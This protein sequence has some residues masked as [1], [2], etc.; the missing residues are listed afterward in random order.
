MSD[1]HRRSR[2]VIALHSPTGEGWTGHARRARSYQTAKCSRTNVGISFTR[3]ASD[4]TSIE[5]ILRLWLIGVGVGVSA[6]AYTATG[7]GPYYAVPSWDQTLPGATRFLVLT[8]MDS[9]AVLDRE[10][11]VVWE[12]S[13]A[14]GAQNWLLA[15]FHCNKKYV[16]IHLRWRLPTF[17]ELA[18][19]VDRTAPPGSPPNFNPPLP[20]GHPFANVLTTDYW[21][22]TS[23]DSNVAWTVS[24][25]SGVVFGNNLKTNAN[26]VWCV[27]G[28]QGVD[29][30]SMKRR[31]G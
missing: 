2:P 3:E 11:G 31:S 4:D 5:N 14:V 26:R 23:R 29:T 19:L 8:N 16:G 17:Q 30:G 28:G 9:H 6:P 15:H 24:F 22:A 27:R 7:V 12:Q 13:P 21:S 10:T 1:A 20:V 25:V 18:S